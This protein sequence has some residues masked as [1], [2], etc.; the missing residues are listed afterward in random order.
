M[1]R[2]TLAQLAHEFAQ[3][4]KSALQMQIEE[5]NL[6]NSGELQDGFNPLFVDDGWVS[7][8][9]YAWGFVMLY[10]DPL[11]LDT[12][13]GPDWPFTGYRTAYLARPFGKGISFANQLNEGE[14]YYGPSELARAG[15]RRLADKVGDG[16]IF[17]AQLPQAVPVQHGP[18]Y[19]QELWRVI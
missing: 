2:Q 14:V 12:T 4:L 5:L 3:Q 18:Y 19:D 13:C 10:D 6:R 16:W 15:L 11:R 1:E 9:G 8:K 17:D 7:L